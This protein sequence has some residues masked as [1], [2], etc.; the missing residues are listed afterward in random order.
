MAEDRAEALSRETD[1]ASRK[2]LEALEEIATLDREYAELD[3]RWTEEK[4]A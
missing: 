4:A 1:E 3:A 2:R